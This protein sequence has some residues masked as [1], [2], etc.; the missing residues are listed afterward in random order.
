VVELD[1]RG[2][3]AIDHL[4]VVR[5]DGRDLEGVLYRVR[6]DGG[7]VGIGTIDADR[8]GARGAAVSVALRRLRIGAGRISYRWAVV[9]TFTGPGCPRTCI[10][11]VPDGGMVEQLL[12]GVT[13]PPTP[14]PSPT[15][16]PSPTPAA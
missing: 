15:A 8:D 13:P 1:T 4:A 10:D 3:E 12:P 9:T 7:Q 14:S 6:R 16:T 2:D 11:L 5:S